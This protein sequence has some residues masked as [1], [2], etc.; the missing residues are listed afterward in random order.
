MQKS[1]AHHL[2]YTCTLK[3]T[4][5]T[6]ALAPDDHNKNTI[7]HPTDTF[8]DQST[9]TAI[10]L[11]NAKLFAKELSN[12][13]KPIREEINQW[14]NQNSNQNSPTSPYK[15]TQRNSCKI[16]KFIEMIEEIK[17]KILNTPCDWAQEFHIL[18]QC[19]K[20]LIEL[21]HQIST[22]K[23]LSSYT[24]DKNFRETIL[25]LNP[26][27]EKGPIPTQKNFDHTQLKH[28]L[29]YLHQDLKRWEEKFSETMSWENKKL[30]QLR[31]TKQR[32]IFLY[33]SPIQHCATLRSS[34]P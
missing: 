18:C 15:R 21:F 17:D 24:I 5:T 32:S 6:Q 4:H 7:H 29:L 22:P 2:P 8:S 16:N 10:S 25:K 12:V 26:Q 19:R 9:C 30:Q 20:E 34:V 1:Q 13:L 28:S 11:E 23:I 14:I 3:T 33:K 31:K 27:L